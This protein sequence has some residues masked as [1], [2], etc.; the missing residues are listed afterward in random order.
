MPKLQ[1]K[2]KVPVKS[3]ADQAKKHSESSLDGEDDDLDEESVSRLLAAIR[4]I[5]GQKQR[6]G[7]ER[8]CATMNLKYAMPPDET[9][10]LLER[11]V[12]AGR[13]VKLINKG[14]P[15]Y[16]DPDTLSMSKAPM[17][18]SDTARLIKKAVLTINLD[19]ATIRE[20]EESIIKEHGLVHS[21]DFTDQ[22]KGM[23]AKMLESGRL[24]K[25]GRILKV[26]IY[27][28]DP[29][30]EPKVTPSSICS[31]CLGT[32]E[33]NK[34]KKSEQLVSCHECGNSGHPS[35]LQY[36]P[37][38]VDRI[39]AEP[40]LCLE[41]KRCMHCDKGAA[42]DDLLFCDACDKGFHMECLDPPL[43]KLPTGRWICPICVPAPN[44]KRTTRHQHT[45]VE[46]G[47]RSRKSTDYY[48]DY[49]AYTPY[50]M[51]SRKKKRKL[52]MREI[53][54]DY[55]PLP[56]EKIEEA[57]LQLPPGV[58]ES[59][60]TLFKKA[61]ERAFES[62]VITKSSVDPNVKSPA[63]IEF[64]KYEIKA[65]YSSPYPQEYAMLPK[66]YLCEFCLKYMKTRTILKRHRAK[67]NWFHPPANEIYRKNDLSI[68]EVDGMASKIYCQNLCLLAKLF[69]DHKTL[70][71]DVEPFLFYVLTYNDRKGCHLVGYFSKE[72]SCQQK[73]NVSCIMTMP[74]YQRQ[75]YGRFLID[76]SYLLSRVED[77]S[78]SPEKPL[79]DLGRIS[80]HSYW[81][82]TLME[83]LYH[84]STS[85][86]SVR[87]I[88]KD[89]G[90]DP[91]DIAATL[92]MLCMLKLKEDGTVVIVKDATMLEA[93]M[94]KVRHKIRVPLDPDALHWSP[95]VHA[96]PIPVTDTGDESEVNPSASELD[97]K[98]IKEEKK[99]EDATMV[100]TRGG[101]KGGGA[102]AGSTGGA[103]ELAKSSNPLC[104]GIIS[105]SA[106][107]T[108]AQRTRSRRGRETMSEM[109]LR[110]STRRRRGRQ[111]WL[112]RRKRG[113][114]I[115]GSHFLYPKEMTEDV[116][117]GP[118]NQRQ[119]G[120]Y[121]DPVSTRTRSQKNIELEKGKFFNLGISNFQPTRRRRLHT[122]ASSAD[123]STEDASKAEQA[124]ES[125]PERVNS[126]DGRG[127]GSRKWSKVRG[128][129]Y[130]ACESDSSGSDSDSSSSS[131]SNTSS[132]SQEDEAPLT[133]G[134]GV[135]TSEPPPAAPHTSLGPGNSDVE[136]FD[137]KSETSADERVV[138]KSGASKSDL[139]LTGPKDDD[140]SDVSVGGSYAST[141]KGRGDDEGPYEL[142]VSI[143]S[144]SISLPPTAAGLTSESSSD[145]QPKPDQ[146]ESDP[147]VEKP[148]VS[149]AQVDSLS[150]SSFVP[151]QSQMS[152][153]LSSLQTPAQTSL[154]QTPVL[155]SSYPP[156]QIQPP[157]L[158]TPVQSQTPMQSQTP[159]RAPLQQ[160]QTPVQSSTLLQTPMQTLTALS[161][162]HLQS[163]TQASSQLHKTPLQ[164]SL[165]QSSLFSSSLLQRSPLSAASA[166]SLSSPSL[167][168]LAP[169]KASPSKLTTP[170][171]GDTNIS[172]S[173]GLTTQRSDSLLTGLQKPSGTT[174]GTSTLPQLNQMYQQLQQLQ[175]LQQQRAAAGQLTNPPPPMLQYM[176]LL[177][178][179]QRLSNPLLF[180][181]LSYGM[182]QFPSTTPAAA[183]T[184][185]APVTAPTPSAPSMT[186]NVS[187]LNL[188]SPNYWS[189]PSTAPSGLTSLSGIGGY[190]TDSTRVNSRPDT[191]AAGT[192]PS[193]YSGTLYRTPPLQQQQQQQQQQ[194]SPAPTT[195]AM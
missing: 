145:L 94:D 167:S 179:Q 59:D 185:S 149:D 170:F 24:E 93:H 132:M 5:K 123:Y 112:K 35:C 127:N 137:S 21:I 118:Q 50:G 139:A 128:R 111:T 154:L 90:M 99:D 87:T 105:S 88:S 79:S 125:A 41:C 141:E 160:Q 97:V 45:N 119:P 155:Q 187:R 44:R 66:L 20:V 166:E 131:S 14:M 68:Y 25:H 144:S 140:C 75:G 29:F 23:V 172:S 33:Q 27:R 9:L 100:Q 61:Q 77:Q 147:V 115:L 175:M 164:T 156:Q 114:Q 34:Q 36:T 51:S 17:N 76:F 188:L 121:I 103:P 65:W 193:Q 63:M 84:H 124:V 191:T 31:F 117:E 157:L 194:K 171:L 15:S 150:N 53:E 152:H 60:M 189:S 52:D 182:S 42:T 102:A 78:G 183:T 104:P 73:Y 110:R 69:L 130:V 11:A 186:A 108:P 43:E 134:G 13:V 143:S 46:I 7:E 163:P 133:S 116:V 129:R 58:M 178:S 190:G 168:S 4:R 67:C 86:L 106:T 184:T 192:I 3:V 113:K 136:E 82:S 18:P 26:P 153:Q 8:I 37:S 71:Y 40:W 91:H 16:R 126:D 1:R 95:L 48:S 101:G 74:Q 92:Q 161:T 85:K 162:S 176:N 169:V 83:Y 6:P 64:G 158:Q 181:Y 32:A 159:I 56:V 10:I 173:P 146:P 80:Y 12:Q 180:P 138:S 195:S 19:G 30:P 55:E 47:K 174:A 120:D 62:M 107:A 165:L 109:P 148:L 98:N 135:S 22:L 151:Q 38:L 54:E 28:M 39:R 96:A 57:P 70:Y 142:K 49:D 81:K 177:G 122:S 89:T 2:L 72:K